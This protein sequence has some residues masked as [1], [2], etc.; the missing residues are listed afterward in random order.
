MLKLGKI[1]VT[2]NI[3]FKC[4]VI[5]RTNKFQTFKP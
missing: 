4:G 3:F 1:K 2:K 5:E